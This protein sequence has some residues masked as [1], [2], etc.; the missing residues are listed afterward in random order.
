MKT[1]SHIDISDDY[2]WGIVEGIYNTML[3]G[4]IDLAFKEAKR[5]YAEK[6][7]IFFVR[8]PI[9]SERALRILD[10]LNHMTGE[11]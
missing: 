5:I 3:G 6:T 7:E 11:K 8:E 2:I 9:V 1:T 10:K 4:T